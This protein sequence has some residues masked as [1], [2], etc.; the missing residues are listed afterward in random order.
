MVAEDL[1]LQWM[2]NETDRLTQYQSLLIQFDTSRCM[3]CQFYV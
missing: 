3:L 2:A 1:H